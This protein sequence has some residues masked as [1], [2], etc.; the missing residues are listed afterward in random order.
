MVRLVLLGLLFAAPAIAETILD[1]PAFE[2]RVTGKTL[3]FERWGLP[4]GAEQYLPGRRVIWRFQ[5]DRCEHG[6]WFARGEAICFSYD[7]VPGPL[8]WHVIDGADGLRV[9]EIGD[10]PGN[11]LSLRRES[12]AP[13][14]CPGEYLGS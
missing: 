3:H 14:D 11:D 1:G 2:A 7:S 9:R 5:G 12:P 4:Y 6:R 8:C 10:V 13:L